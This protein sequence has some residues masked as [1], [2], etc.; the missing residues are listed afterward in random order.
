MGMILHSQSWGL[1]QE[2]LGRVHFR[3]L[4]I[5]LMSLYL[6][7]LLILIYHNLSNIL[8]FKCRFWWLKDCILKLRTTTKK[9]FQKRDYNKSTEE[10]KL[11]GKSSVKNK[12][13]VLSQCIS[14]QDID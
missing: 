12:V 5:T 6:S 10:K 11:V 13:F 3:I 9:Q 4:Q 2:I 14:S 1:R 8:L 7:T